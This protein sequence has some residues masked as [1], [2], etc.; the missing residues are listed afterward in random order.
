MHQCKN[1][2]LHR[3][4]QELFEFVREE[5]LRYREKLPM[6]QRLTRHD[7]ALQLLVL[8][9]PASEE[10][11][12]RYSAEPAYL[13]PAHCRLCLQPTDDLEKHLQQECPAQEKKN[14]EVQKSSQQDP[15]ASQAP[16]K[17]Q[18]YRQE[19]FAKVVKEWP[20]PISPQV[21]RSRL[22]AFK[23][24]MCDDAFKLAAC[25]SC[26]RQK[27]NRDLKPVL[28]PPVDAV[29]CPAWLQDHWSNEE[30][31]IHRESWFEQLDD[32]LNIDSYLR[33][34]FKV[35]ERLSSAA[36]AVASFDLPDVTNQN[37]TSKEE[38]ESW[39]RRVQQ[40][41]ENLQQDLMRDSVPA[42][43]EPDKRWLL[44][45][46]GSLQIDKRTGGISCNLC[47][48]CL[49]AFAKVKPGGT[50]EP[51]VKMPSR[52]RANGLWH[53]PDPEELR[54]LSY[55][56]CKVINMARIY[57]SVKRVFLERESYAGTSH[58]ETPL[59]HQ[60]NVVAYPQSPGSLVFLFLEQATHFV[61]LTFP[62]R[63]ERQQRQPRR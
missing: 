16:S 28:F 27:C 31:S 63:S 22:A 46:N 54:V 61:P 55:T 32:V 5:S 50:K 56:E 47:K 62:L 40:W 52:A 42:P 23:N 58:S 14:D 36:V 49:T 4:K 38:A 26:A 48:E 57:V 35:Q 2:F 24:A 9:T 60:R 29:E 51:N 12:P 11:L 6:Q 17:T 43:G 18:V 13:S 30:W 34:F 59:Y 1:C 8:P 10:P 20:Q 45:Q 41:S 21:L 39:L 3:S 19:V 44:F 7:P 33:V 15:A 53:G 25:A 37:F